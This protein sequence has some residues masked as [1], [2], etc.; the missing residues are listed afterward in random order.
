VVLKYGRSHTPIRPFRCWWRPKYSA[1]RSRRYTHSSTYCSSR[2]LPNAPAS[3]ATEAITAKPKSCL[4]IESRNLYRR[5]FPPLTLMPRVPYYNLV[6]CGAS[7]ILPL[8][9]Q[10]RILT[11]FWQHNSIATG[12]KSDTSPVKKCL[13][14]TSPSTVRLFEWSN[15]LSRRRSSR[16]NNSYIGL[17]PKRGGANAAPQ[18]KI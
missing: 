7:T 4:V 13:N 2:C 9:H 15:L 18:F 1:H 6:Q 8:L 11:L 3:S 10:R 17:W 5:I 12:W 16:N 14:L